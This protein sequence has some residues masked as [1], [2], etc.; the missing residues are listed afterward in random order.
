MLSPYSFRG[1]VVFLKVPKVII[2]RFDEINV[3]GKMWIHL[4]ISILGAGRRQF[5][6]FLTFLIF[7]L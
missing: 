1:F 4:Y 2:I 6:V 5:L 3:L 7:Y